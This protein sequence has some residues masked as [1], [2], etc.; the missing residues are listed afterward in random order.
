MT[1][2]SLG[3]RVQGL[4]VQGLRFR[5]EGIPCRTLPMLFGIASDF[6]GETLH[7]I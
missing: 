7:G 6:I 3:F 5:V 2:E 1:V 4:W